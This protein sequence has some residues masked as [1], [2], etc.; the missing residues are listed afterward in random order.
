MC[1]SA[2]RPSTCSSAKQGKRRDSG[3][4]FATTLILA[5]AQPWK[6]IRRSCCVKFLAKCYIA[7][8]QQGLF[9]HLPLDM[10]DEETKG[11]HLG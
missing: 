7:A 10:P 11:L 5:S 9:G 4:D 1:A 3:D 6:E 8:A 2:L